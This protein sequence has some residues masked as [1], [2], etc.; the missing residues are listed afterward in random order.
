[1]SVRRRISP[2]AEPVLLSGAMR[3]LDRTLRRIADKDVIV[4]LVGESG[5]GKEVLA[6]RIHALSARRAERF[7][8]INC[9]AIPDALF[10]SELF[11]HERGAFTGASELMRGKVEAA[12]G[13][14]LFLDEI[15]ELPLGMQAK[16]LRFL[17]GLRF[18]RVGGT[19][20]L[21]ADVRLI[22]AT[23]RPL[24]DEVRR[25]AFRADLYYRIQGITLSVP[26]LRERR[27][28]IAPLAAALL[29]ELAR[30]HGVKAPKLTRAA[31]AAFQGYAWPGNVRELR[32]V[33]EQLCLLRPGRSVRA[34]DLPP[35]LRLPEPHEASDPSPPSTLEISLDE[36]LGASVER[37]IHAAV[38]LEHGNRSRAADRLGI[39][40]RTVQ[41]KLR[42][43]HGG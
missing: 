21:H 41:R 17:E 3:R 12:A 34:A 14:T 29:A 20:K 43:S 18:M 9:A 22:C 1:M 11:G 19:E 30:R 40:L 7:V 2:E 27:A 26:A 33:L 15:G 6:R 31:I 28:D 8:P 16:L 24:E 42:T 39:G 10:E 5:S 4:C 38:A 25:G 36:P 13:G 23:L 37:I 32:N 35:A